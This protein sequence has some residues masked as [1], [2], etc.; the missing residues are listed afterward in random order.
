MEA[1]GNPMDILNYSC[2]LKDLDDEYL[3]L[4][5]SSYEAEA[6]DKKIYTINS[7]INRIKLL[8]KEEFMKFD[9][10]INELLKKKEK[11]KKIAEKEKI[12]P[13]ILISDKIF[14]VFAPDV[15][16]TSNKIFYFL[17]I[18]AFVVFYCIIHACV[19]MFYDSLLNN[20]E[21]FKAFS[22]YFS[23]L[24]LFISITNDNS[25]FAKISLYLFEFLFIYFLSVNISL[26]KGL[27]QIY[28]VICS[29]LLI[30][31]ISYNQLIKAKNKEHHK[32]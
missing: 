23:C 3:F 25:S 5:A 16:V 4:I 10:K 9:E 17:P 15:D 30:I 19:F 13:E 32:N 29:Y 14:F 12:K 27:S 6:F 26:G 2:K 21:M 7:I 24:I 22:Q 11:D 31:Y 20:R 28:M 1:F 8:S 18:N